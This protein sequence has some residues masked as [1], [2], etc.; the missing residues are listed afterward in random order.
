LV[1]A[2]LSDSVESNQNKTKIVSSLRDNDGTNTYSFFRAC[3]ENWPWDKLVESRLGEGR[4][5]FAGDETSGYK[6]QPE[7]FWYQ[8][9]LVYAMCSNRMTSGTAE[10][11][12][13]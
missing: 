9:D 12:R 11:D 3:K 5:L 1:L 10:D 4:R 8:N 7:I 13:I 2:H 6:C